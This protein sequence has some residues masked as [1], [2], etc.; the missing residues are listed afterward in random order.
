VK[1]KTEPTLT[2]L[3]DAAFR[4]AARKVVKRAKVTGTAVLVWKNGQIVDLLE[5][6]NARKKAKGEARKSG[7]RK[8]KSR[9]ATRAKDSLGS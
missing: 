7:K 2:E 6:K 4:R 1:R 8:V 5:A 9:R 3:A